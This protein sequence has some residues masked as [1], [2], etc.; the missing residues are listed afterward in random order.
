MGEERG[1]GGQRGVAQRNG[2]GLGRRHA[3]LAT[4]GSKRRG[5]E[6][7]RHTASSPLTCHSDA[8]ARRTVMQIGMC[9][10]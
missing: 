7:R 8:N 9:V 6:D 10:G 2:V 5:F 3:A 4:A 1:V